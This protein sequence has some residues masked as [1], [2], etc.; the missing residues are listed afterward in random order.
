MIT[1]QELIDFE[2]EI[3]ERFNNRE[4]R[5]PIH[6]YHGNEDQIMQVFAG[7]SVKQDWVCCTW[8]NHYQAQECMSL[9]VCVC[10]CVCA[11]MWCVYVMMV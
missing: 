9:Y 4:I 8:R 2:T 6:L 7:I 10:V 5:A 3:G 1:K 11:M